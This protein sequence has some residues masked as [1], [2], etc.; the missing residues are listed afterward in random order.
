MDSTIR[1]WFRGPVTITDKQGTRVDGDWLDMPSM[2]RATYSVRG[3]TEQAPVGARGETIGSM[4]Q[5]GTMVAP[6]VWIDGRWTGPVRVEARIDTA[7]RH[8][9]AA[10]TARCAAIARDET[11]R[12]P[13]LE[14]TVAVACEAIVEA[15]VGR[16]RAPKKLA[17]GVS[18]GEIR[19]AAT[20]MAGVAEAVTPEM[21]SVALLA[22]YPVAYPS[23]PR[24]EELVERMAGELAEGLSV[25][26]LEPRWCPILPTE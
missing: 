2:M 24:G 19:D 9:V 22:A 3:F 8:A 20:V 16:E 7:V 17:E 6:W 13:G 26:V 10:E 4:Q 21:A 1:V 11:A 25:T 18:P 23:A 5:A 12:W 14:D 15:V